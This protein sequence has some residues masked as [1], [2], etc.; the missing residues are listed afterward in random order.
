MV[1]AGHAAPFV[2]HMNIFPNLS[3][4]FRSSL[5]L[6]SYSFL[7]GEAGTVLYRGT[8]SMRIKRGS[9]GE[10]EKRGGK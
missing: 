4:T 1:K 10:R 6:I 5:S 3:V 7:L 9:G 2:A 8:A